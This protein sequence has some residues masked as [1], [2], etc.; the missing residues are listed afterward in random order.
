[1]Q[2]SE[3]SVP[4][5]RI[6]REI[7]VAAVLTGLALFSVACSSTADYYPPEYYAG[8]QVDYYGQPPV[9]YQSD[10]PDRYYQVDPGFAPSGYQGHQ[11]YQEYSYQAPV[12]VNERPVAA[13]RHYDAYA[14]PTFQAGPV[15]ET[16]PAPA[17]TQHRPLI[18]GEILTQQELD[19]LER[20]QREVNDRNFGEFQAPAKPAPEVGESAYT[21]QQADETARRLADAH[22]TFSKTTTPTMP[23]SNVSQPAVYRPAYEEP[24]AVAPVYRPPVTGSYSLVEQV[25]RSL[26]DRGYPVGPVDGVM[27]Q[28]TRNALSSFQAAN[29]LPVTGSTD[30]ATLHALGVYH[31]QA[32]AA[33]AGGYLP[34]VADYRRYK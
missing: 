2:Q 32:P 34:R 14:D 20:R 19:A 3:K 18:Q 13:T 6:F 21:E 27:G 7:E 24:V 8:Q 10:Q 25:Q 5:Y 28:R 33:P 16:Y 23:L 4:T 12:I 9:G 30:A 26:N 11:G 17:V 31:V 29:A 22:A 1:M 15:I